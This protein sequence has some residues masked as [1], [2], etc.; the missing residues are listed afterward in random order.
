MNSPADLFDKSILSLYDAAL[1]ADEWA[2]ALRN[3]ARL[4]GAEDAHYIVFDNRTLEVMRLKAGFD[5]AALDY[6]LHEWAA[7]GECPRLNNL[8]AREDFLQVDYNHSSERV[9]RKSD[10][11][12]DL[13][14]RFDEKYSYTLGG[15]LPGIDPLNP[16]VS[17]T[18]SVVFSGRHGHPQA[19][20]LEMAARVSPHLLRASKIAVARAQACSAEGA[21][22]HFSNLAGRGAIVVGTDC[23][24]V[25]QN[26]FAENILRA[27]D[28]LCLK[29]GRLSA[30]L[31]SDTIRLRSMVRGAAL[32]AKGANS[33]PGGAMSISR[34]GGGPPLSVVVAPMSVKGA[35][36]FQVLAARAVV[37]VTNRDSTPQISLDR[38]KILYGFTETEARVAEKFLSGMATNEIARELGITIRTVRFHFSN[39][40]EKAGVKGQTDLMRT[41]ST[42][43]TY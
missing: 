26:A 3:I 17:G 43:L 35:E 32:F 36:L 19:F 15:L 16:A 10:Y 29:K 1:G 8:L 28:G 7:R 18:F 33:V 31:Y 40:F 14:K 23:H 12:V 22:E 41:L 2:L 24:V 6:W 39:L 25:S 20:E 13:N 5:Q 4:F 42:G 11:F 27:D 34:P 38:L 30:R 21:I 37:F 9:M